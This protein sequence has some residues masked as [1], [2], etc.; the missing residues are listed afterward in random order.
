MSVRTESAHDVGRTINCAWNRGGCC[1]IR[2]GDCD[3]VCGSDC[4]DRVAKM[5]KK[6]KQRRTHT[7]HGGFLRHA[8][9]LKSPKARMR[10]ITY[11]ID[12]GV[13]FSQCTSKKRY[14][15]EYRA[16]EVRRLC[17]RSRGQELR[18]YHCRWCDGYHLTSKINHRA[19][20]ME[21]A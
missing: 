9:L 17:T 4:S 3:C 21:V 15:T 8:I 7:F 6:E 19:G 18:V 10:R 11:G 1:L 5:A 12:R 13:I 2:K 16:N 14:R 20:M